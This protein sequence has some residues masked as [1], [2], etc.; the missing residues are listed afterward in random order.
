MPLVI[1][2]AQQKGGSGKTSLAV[3]LSVAWASP[4]RVEASR[5]KPGQKV[6]ALDLD[7]QRSLSRWFE[8]R[9]RVASDGVALEVRGLADWRGVGEAIRSR[10]D[11]D[12]VVIDLPAGEHVWARDVFAA[13][14]LVLVPLQLSPMDL[15]ATAPT[16]DAINEAGSNALVI[17]NRMPPHAR[18]S[19]DVIAEAKSMGWPLAHT[20]LGNRVAF[21]SSLMAGKCVTED[22]PSSL[23]AAEIRLLAREV[24]TRARAQACAVELDRDDDA[25][26]PAL[27]SR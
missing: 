20:C 19:D 22:M 13:S 3:H 25:A 10:Q 5:F 11:A 17:L 12:I 26:L 27:A 9:Q 24:L 18:L 1:T 4:Q 7:P 2:V 6:F 8:A 16:I 15:W 14:S 23:A 21:A